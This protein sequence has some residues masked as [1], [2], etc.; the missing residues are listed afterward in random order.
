MIESITTENIY[1]NHLRFK[2]CYV[3]VLCLKV[4]LCRPPSGCHKEVGDRDEERREEQWIRV[5][6]SGCVSHE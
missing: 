6:N 5:E 2:T 4:Q 1:D 3:I